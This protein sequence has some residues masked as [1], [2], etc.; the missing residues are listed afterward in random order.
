MTDT[1][2]VD[3]LD[4][5]DKFEVELAGLLLGETR[6]SHDIVEE[7]STVAVFH[8]HV[9]LFLSFNDFIQL[10]HVRMADLLEDL[11]FSS[12]TLDILLVVNLV[13]LQD[14]YG[15]LQFLVIILTYL[16]TCQGVLSKLY[17]TKGSL[18]EMFTY[19]D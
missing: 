4:T 8:D 16:F 15:N 18:A 11:D 17:L 9:Q 3:I 10:D 13:F 6:V 2:L 5:R 7:L 1:R 19:N 12:D 14:L